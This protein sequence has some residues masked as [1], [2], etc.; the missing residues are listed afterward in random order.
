MTAVLR[1]VGGCLL[2]LPRAVGLVLVLAWMGAVWKLSSISKPVPDGVRVP[3]FLNDLAHAPLFGLG[4]FASLIALPRRLE[5]FRW[6]ALGRREWGLVLGLILVY[7]AVDELHQSTTPG[8]D[9]SPGDVLT[10]L[11]GGLAVLIVAS[12]LG[13]PDADSAGTWRRLGLCALLCLAAAA[14]STYLIRV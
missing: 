1:S 4:A 12:Y 3:L 8:R 5:P 14:S 7:A 2:R 9:A 11:T 6:P 10:D 13:R